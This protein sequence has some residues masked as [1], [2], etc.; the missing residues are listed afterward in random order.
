MD[1][2]SR[3]PPGY[4]DRGEGSGALFGGG[5]GGSNH[6]GGDPLGGT[7]RPS[8]VA[9]FHEQSPHPSR[10]N[11]PTGAPSPTLAPPP[12]AP[13]PQP[14]SNNPPS[15]TCHKVWVGGL[16]PLTTET[17]LKRYFESRFGFPVDSADVKRDPETGASRGFAFVVFRD[18]AAVDEV[19]RA[20]QPPRGGG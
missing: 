15:S 3:P 1:G 12:E 5:G 8:G 10:N 6:G 13:P 11:C 19:L 17:S 4:D 20:G 2:S 16:S 7:W 14:S 9:S 18:G